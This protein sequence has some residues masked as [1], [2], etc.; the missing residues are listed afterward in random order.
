MKS[1]F[2]TTI[3][4]LSLLSSVDAFATIRTTCEDGIGSQIVLTTT[5]A[6]TLVRRP[7]RDWEN[8][9]VIKSEISGSA[10]MNFPW[11]ETSGYIYADGTVYLSYQHARSDLYFLGKWHG[12][13]SLV[14]NVRDSNHEAW[15][16]THCF[17][18]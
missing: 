3:A 15:R 9:P 11:S 5:G 18:E 2:L 8:V 7:G 17:S 12:D 1:F 13:S 16:F 4:G 14:F 6:T 10:M